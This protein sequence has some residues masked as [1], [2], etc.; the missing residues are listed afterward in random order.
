MWWLGFGGVRAGH[1][2]GCEIKGFIFGFLVWVVFLGDGLAFG[3]FV[4][5][6]CDGLREIL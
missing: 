1:C 6:S 2:L 5:K 4:G 3:G